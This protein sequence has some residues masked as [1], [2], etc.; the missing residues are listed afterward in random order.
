MEGRSLVKDSVSSG[1]D[2]WPSHV[3][4]RV[5]ARL[6]LSVLTECDATVRHSVLAKGFVLL[7]N[8]DSR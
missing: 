4:Q 1:H 3:G 7:D 8:V 6:K 2:A 5:Q